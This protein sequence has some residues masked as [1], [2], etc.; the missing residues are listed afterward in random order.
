MIEPEENDTNKVPGD[1]T[2]DAGHSE[3]FY[4]VRPEPHD[5]QDANEAEKAK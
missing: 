5:G 4:D 2:N 3:G 1:N